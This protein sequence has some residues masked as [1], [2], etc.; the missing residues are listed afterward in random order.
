MILLQK[1][2]NPQGEFGGK[3][4]PMTCLFVVAY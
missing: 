4:N 1:L 3:E 2:S